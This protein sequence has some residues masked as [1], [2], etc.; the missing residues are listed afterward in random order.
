MVGYVR[1][2]NLLY[3]GLHITKQKTWKM[4]HFLKAKFLETLVLRSLRTSSAS[5]NDTN[6]SLFAGAL[7]FCPI[8]PLPLVT[9]IDDC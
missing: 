1:T 4:K 8:I 3:V 9:F 5:M 7:A 6:N 2:P